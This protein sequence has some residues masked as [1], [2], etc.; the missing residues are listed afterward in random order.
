MSSLCI[1]DLYDGRD[2]TN[3]ASDDERTLESGPVITRGS[4]GE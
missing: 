4:G 1:Y 2:V 3:G